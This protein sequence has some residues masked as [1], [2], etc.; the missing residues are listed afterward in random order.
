MCL[1][2]RTQQIYS[3]KDVKPVSWIKT[4]FWEGPRW[5]S[6]FQ[7]KGPSNDFELDEDEILKE[8]KESAVPALETPTSIEIFRIPRWNAIPSSTS[9]SNVPAPQP[10]RIAQNEVD[11]NDRYSTL[12]VYLCV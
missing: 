9:K 5:L 10:E 7:G 6:S 12:P 4:R 8:R 2:L 3:R 1:G 11:F